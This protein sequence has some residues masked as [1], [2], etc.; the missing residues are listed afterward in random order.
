MACGTDPVLDIVSVVATALMEAFDPEQDCPPIGGGS[1]T[2]RMFAGDG[3]PLVASE[4]HS[5]GTKCR[6]PFLW[7]RQMRRYRSANFPAPTLAKECKLP[8]V[9]PIEIGV[10][11][12]AV[13]DEQPTWNE[14]AR[15]AQVSSDDAWRI[16]QALCFALSALS[17]A[18]RTVGTD[19]INPYGPEGGVVAWTGILYST[20]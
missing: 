18:D 9:V 11:R 14:Y 3:I 8:R 16:E 4:L 13:A 1:D 19:T 20:Y 5:L 15:E 7:V 17:E 2:V 10:G 6:Q 12:C